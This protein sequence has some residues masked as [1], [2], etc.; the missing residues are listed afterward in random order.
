MGRFNSQKHVKYYFLCV[1]SSLL[2]LNSTSP[3]WAQ[4][5]DKVTIKSRQI[6]GYVFL[7]R[8]NAGGNTIACVGD[9]GIVLVDSDFSQI[10]KKLTDALR[11][12]SQKPVTTL[13]NTHWHFDHT[14]GNKHF[15]ERGCKIIAHKNVRERM[16]KDQTIGILNIDVKASPPAALPQK[17]VKDS[18]H[19]NTGKENIMIQHLPQAHTDG[20]ICVFFKNSNVLHTGDLV[21]NGSYPFI[22][23]F[24]GGSIDGMIKGLDFMSGLCN[25]ETVIVPGHGPLLNKIRLKEYRAMLMEFR[26]AVDKELRSGKTLEQTQNSDALKEITRKWGY[27]HFPPP[28]FIKMVYLSLSK[29]KGQ[30][31]SS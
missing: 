20:D 31:N 28:M 30:V 3:L 23:V 27:R 22:D 25:D 5:W 21:F 9:K 16:S 17:L 7:L 29:K 8:S 26:E 14:G 24:G 19:L 15:A 2:F 13:I 4:N 10:S 1:F 6:N 12:I 11:E 18:M